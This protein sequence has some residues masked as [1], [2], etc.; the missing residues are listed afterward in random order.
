M[1]FR[2]SL[3]SGEVSKNVCAASIRSDETEAFLGIEPL[4]FALLNHD[5]ER[6]KNN[7]GIALHQERKT[8]T[9]Y[10][11][12]SEKLK[13]DVSLRGLRYVGSQLHP[14][15]YPVLKKHAINS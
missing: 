13:G 9:A 15:A 7:T 6:P 4:N 5:M 11:A 2:S 12:F 1:L 14:E 3:N 8:R 10:Q